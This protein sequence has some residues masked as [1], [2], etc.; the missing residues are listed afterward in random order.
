MVEE[1]SNLRSGVF[2]DK[3]INLNDMYTH[4]IDV[5]FK[6]A[7][8]HLIKIISSK[9]LYMQDPV[10][11]VGAFVCDRMNFSFKAVD[12]NRIIQYLYEIKVLCK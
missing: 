3:T 10:S 6:I 9:H 12:S 8:I 2:H 5:G 7:C 4:Q 11:M 1:E